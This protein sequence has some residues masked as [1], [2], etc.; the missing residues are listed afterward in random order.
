MVMTTF[1]DPGPFAVLLQQ[2]RAAAGFSQDELA[3]RAG[4]SRRGISDLERGRRRSPH[5]VTVRQLAEALNL[6]LRERAA[7]LVSA[8]SV[9][10]VVAAHL[11]APPLPVSLTSAL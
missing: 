11:P 6:G 10:V 8:H 7:L 3:E 4:L 1:G 9:N 5:P 2:H